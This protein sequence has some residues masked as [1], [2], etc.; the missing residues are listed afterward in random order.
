MRALTME[1][2]QWVAGGDAAGDFMIDVGRG[3]QNWSPVI[4]AL[5]N[6][7]GMGAALVGTA[8]VN[9]GERRNAADSGGGSGGGTAGGPGP[10]GGG[11]GNPNPDPG[12]HGGTGGTTCSGGGPGDGSGKMP[13][14]VCTGGH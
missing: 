12:M 6:R 9:Q 10:T 5:N 14:V 4:G 3:L 1:E 2:V 8:L 7:A 13:P 11:G